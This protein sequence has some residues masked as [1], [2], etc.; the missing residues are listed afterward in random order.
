MRVVD[1]KFDEYAFIYTNKTKEGVSEIL[2]G[3][4]SKSLI[5]SA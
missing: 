2:N 3:L 4:Y 1:A 5:C